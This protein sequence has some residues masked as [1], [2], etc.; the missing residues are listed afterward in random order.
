LADNGNTITVNGNFAG[1]AAHISTGAGKI[2]LAGGSQPHT[3]SRTGA[4]GNLELDDAEG[5]LVT[6]AFT[7]N[8]DFS[9]KEWCILFRSQYHN[10]F[11]RD[12][13]LSGSGWILRG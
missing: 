10:Y 9:P 11:G 12:H 1:T 2:L 13:F 6:A 5:S 7:V 3:I 4:V 8:G